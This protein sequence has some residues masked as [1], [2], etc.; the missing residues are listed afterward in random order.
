MR[1]EGRAMRHRIGGDTA[2]G[3]N[4]QSQLMI[5]N[6][7]F[8]VYRRDLK[9]FLFHPPRD[10][11]ETASDKLITRSFTFNSSAIIILSS[12][13]HSAAFGIYCC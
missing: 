5:E 7:T 4:N 11:N 3:Y 2:A 10:E 1:R 13:Q 6:A 8:L 9:R 12:T